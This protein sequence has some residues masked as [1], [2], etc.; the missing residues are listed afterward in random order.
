[1]L[2][3][4]L[5]FVL[6]ALS[7]A[8]AVES[9]PPDLIVRLHARVYQPGEVVL[10]M[11][12]CPDPL[13]SLHVEAFGRS[14]PGFAVDDGKNWQALIGIDL[15]TRP[16]KYRL[17]IRGKTAAGSS[18][19]ARPE[20]AVL[21]KNFPTR[22]LT[23]E[24][25]YVRPSKEEEER[26]AREAKKVES[27]FTST[28]EER[29][30]K[31]PFVAPVPGDPISSFGKRSIV[32][33]QARSPHSGTDFKGS[34]G[35]PVKAPAGGRVILSENLYF[36][37]NTIILDHGL[38]VYSF[39]AHLSVMIVKE[40]STVRRGELIGRVGAT[41]RVTGPHLHWTLR[42]CGA[43]IDPLS[44]IEVLQDSTPLKDSDHSRIK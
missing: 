32:N 22:H 44:L 30:W 40:G 39:M 3:R 1:M 20:I 4:T 33:G 2:P 8:V 9:G 19:A 6:L 11:I 18:A 14:F 12:S 7:L 13:A 27:I 15:A 16:G 29:L 43:R 36:S 41:G 21:Q 31:E 37:G 34:T 5:F 28:S 24:E 10:A 42:L 26:I 38:G 17:E 35:T 25:K 23:V